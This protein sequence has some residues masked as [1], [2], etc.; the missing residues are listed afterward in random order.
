MML[1]R[2]SWFPF[3]R[4]LLLGV[5]LSQAMSPSAQA[6]LAGSG[7]VTARVFVCPDGLSLSAVLASN[8]PSTPL[9]GCDP[10]AG[11]V[12]APRLRIAAEDSPK[13]GDVFA[14]GVYLWTGLPFG[15]YEFS[16]GDVPSGFGDRL[17]TNG[18]DVAVADQEHGV[19]AI[20]GVVPDIE[21]RFYYFV[22]PDLP[23]GTIS[24]T[25]Y[26][27]PDAD[28]LSPANCMLMVDPP[29]DRALL[30]PDLW[31]DP[32]VG[33]YRSG[34]AAWH[35]LPF[36]IYSITH[37]G[38]LKPGEAA[39]VPELACVSPDRCAMLIGPDAP[40]AQLELYVFPI[41]VGARDSDSDGFADPHELAGGTDPNDPTSPGPDRGHSE[42]DS[43]ADRLSDQDEAFYRTDTNNPDTDGD[44]ISDGNEIA[45]GTNPVALP[46]PDN[47]IADHNGD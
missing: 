3:L 30:F 35:G 22:S 39:A 42:A 12:I 47:G 38:V 31:T 43:D 21:R 19:V 5:L 1:L 41:P 9:A 2:Y 6:R 46:D 32:L 8:D 16:G 28:T 11:A 45:I 24:L 33:I 4:A 14:E 44:S 27:C 13:P 18:S 23:A 34:R 10:S 29:A 15:S 7:S 17:I 36:G 20:R 37:S 26:R 25:L 40:S